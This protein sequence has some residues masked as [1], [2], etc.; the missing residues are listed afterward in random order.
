M[1]LQGGGAPCACQAGLHQAMHEASMAP[2]RAIG[3]SSGVSSG[4]LIGV[5]I[6]V[7]IG[8][9]TAAVSADNPTEK[10]LEQPGRFRTTIPLCRIWQFT[11]NRDFFHGVRNA[12]S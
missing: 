7:S 9:I 6:G 8:A 12:T 3:L 5:S 11:S 4:E 2:D 1:M 10:S